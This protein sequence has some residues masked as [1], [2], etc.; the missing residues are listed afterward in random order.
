MKELETETIWGISKV[1]EIKNA[2]PHLVYVV[3][4]RVNV[5]NIELH[6]YV[7][8]SFIWRDKLL[9]VQVYQLYSRK[10]AGLLI[11][12][13]SLCGLISLYLNYFIVHVGLPICGLF[14]NKTE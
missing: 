13:D 9:A 12:E 3:R 8:L 6:F 14:Q 2:I 1:A 4:V 11:T 7:L 5:Q 10:E